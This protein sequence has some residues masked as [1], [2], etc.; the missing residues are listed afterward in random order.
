MSY[1]LTAKLFKKFD[2]IQRTDTF[3]AREFVMETDGQYPQYVKFQLV[4][5]RCAALDPYSEGQ[6]IK[7]FFDLRG[8]EWNDPKSGET[9]YFTNLNAWKIESV[10]PAAPV[11]GPQ[12][13]GVQTTNAPTAQD[14]P[15]MDADDLPF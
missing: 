1:E 15:Q 14:L 5:D 10:A 2:T 9:K 7:V 3:S 6:Q 8:R 13:S 4:Q 12:G 11:Q